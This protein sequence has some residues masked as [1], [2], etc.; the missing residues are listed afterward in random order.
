MSN[1]K[2][3]IVITTI[4]LVFFLFSSCN[5]LLS[6]NVPSIIWSKH[7]GGSGNDS[8]FSVTKTTDGRFVLLGKSDST[9]H[10]VWGTHGVDD[11][12]IADL[13]SDGTFRGQMI[14]GG[15]G[16]DIG[17][18]IRQTSDNGYALLG[19]SFS[20][21]GT[22]P[23]NNGLYDFY[24]LKLTTA[25]TLGWQMN[26]GG[27]DVDLAQSL[28]ETDDNQYILAGFTGSVD[29]DVS[30]HHGAM[31]MWIVKVNSSDHVRWEK[32]F[33]GSNQDYAH[34]IKQTND[35]HY[36]VAGYTNST[37]GD[38]CVN[39]GMNDCWIIKLNDFG[40]IIWHAT[41]GGSNDDKALSIEPTTDNGYIMAGGSKSTDGDVTENHGGMDCWIVKLDAWGTIEWQKSYGGSGNEVATAIKQTTDGGYIAAGTSDSIDG[42]VTGNH[43]DLDVWVFKLNSE[44]NLQWQKS[45]GGTNEDAAHSLVLS[46][47]NGYI[48]AGYSESDNGNVPGNY[49]NR[50]YWVVKLK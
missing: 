24:F 2:R 8:A 17:S 46:D 37:N 42:D 9:D 15:T 14:F 13:N 22:L 23:G 48:I 6:V 45:L 7:F 34:S 41:L 25:G 50:D 36:I 26:C 20:N 18:C 10:D 49:G 39:H 40:N 28:V 32:T 43:G 29:G 21:D 1:F 11:Y 35:G 38:I 19:S 27:S 12:W 4:I 16:H 47:D 44:G 31:D 33:G 5:T 30:S 3:L